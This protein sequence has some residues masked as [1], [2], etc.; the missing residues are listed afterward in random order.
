MNTHTDRFRFWR[1]FIL[2]ALLVL[3]FSSEPS[4][5]ASRLPTSISV[6][7]SNPTCYQVLPAN[8]ACSIQINSLTAS[9]SDASFAR[10]ELLVNGK[11]RINMAGFFEASASLTSQMIPGGLMVACGRLNE[12]GLPNYGRAYT[13]TV[14]AYMADNTSATGSKVVLCPAFEGSTFIPMVRNKR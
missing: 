4:R 1:V 10:V 8:G 14:I 7:M 5:A 9:G 6:S 3:G 13:V 11:L 12:G 2:S